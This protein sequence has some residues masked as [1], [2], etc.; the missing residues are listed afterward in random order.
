MNDS[1]RRPCSSSAVVCMRSQKTGLARAS[2]P[3]TDHAAMP[4]G[5]AS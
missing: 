2:S 1:K 5:M 4:T 3:A